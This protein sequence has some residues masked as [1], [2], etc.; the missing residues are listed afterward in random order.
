MESIRIQYTSDIHLEFLKNEPNLEDFVIPSAPYL[1]ILGDLGYPGSKNYLTFL[2]KASQQY[3]KVFVIA[4]NH[5]FYSESSMTDIMSNIESICSNLSNVFFLNNSEHLLEP[6]LVLLGTTLWSKID[7]D[8]S[9]LVQIYINDYKYI[10]KK[11]DDRMVP[12]TPND[13]NEIHTQS[14]KWLEDSLE[15]HKDKRIVILSHHLPSYK[16]VHKNYQYH[17]MNCAFATD[18][19]YLILKYS[20]IKYWL[21]GHTHKS[22]K[23][24]VNKCTMSVNPFGYKGENSDYDPRKSLYITNSSNEIYKEI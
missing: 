24:V 16:L 8:R 12:I 7:D 2:E 19:E 23:E 21:C 20:S 13:I 6:D 10:H 5:E 15:K 14:V 17:P 11:V 1:A 3:Q 9:E 18:L 22:M 4:G